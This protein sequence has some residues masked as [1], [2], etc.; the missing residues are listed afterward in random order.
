MKLCVVT[1]G[2]RATAALL[3]KLFHKRHHADNISQTVTSAFSGAAMLD[4]IRTLEDVPC[5]AFALDLLRNDS[6]V[7]THVLAS[8]HQPSVSGLQ[9]NIARRTDGQGIKELHAAAGS[10][11]VETLRALVCDGGV[12]P[13]GRGRFG[14]TALHLAAARG[15]ARAV[16]LI[17]ALALAAP[18]SSSRLPLAG[19]ADVLGWTALHHAAFAGQLECA[20]QL[21]ESGCGADPAAR[22]GDGQ[23]PADLAE[24]ACARQHASRFEIADSDALPRGLVREAQAANVAAWETYSRFLDTAVYLRRL[25]GSAPRAPRPAP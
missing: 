14:Q 22:D 12:D 1:A 25:A 17:C 11:M 19:L 6:W 8:S 21:V 7:Q 18:D 24:R 13:C 2:G 5:S 9:W 4:A 23:T 16:E 3:E 10:G 20:R 15:Q